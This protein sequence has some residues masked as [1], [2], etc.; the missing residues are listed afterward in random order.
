MKSPIL[1]LIFNR[2]DTTRQVFEE[3]RKARPPRLYIAADGPRENRMGEKER[4]EETRAIALNIDWDCEIKTLFRDVNLGCG[5]AVSEAIT[6]FFYN[7]PEGIIIEDDIIPHPEFFLFCDEMLEKYRN[8]ESIQLITGR[9]SFFDGYSSEYSYYMSSYFHIWGWAS[10]RRVWRTY[11]FDASKLSREV[12]LKNISHRIP[13]EGVSY[14]SKVFDI[15]SNHQCDTWDY[16]LYFNQILHNRY[17]IIPYTNLTRNIGFGI[18]ATHTA[19]EN[20]EQEKHEGKPI[21]PLKHPAGIFIDRKADWTHMRKM[22]LMK[23]N[24]FIRG[25]NKLNKFLK[26]ILNQKDEL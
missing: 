25:I 26:G 8:D 17:S 12:F 1:F 9:N 22:G 13:K 19:I 2:P 11:N 24:I 16:Q 20:S 6:W 10:W 3:I 15:M 5:K 7:E 4:C 14:W 21:Y 18:D 23:K